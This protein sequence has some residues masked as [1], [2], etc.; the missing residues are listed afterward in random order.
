MFLQ[1]IH[2]GLSRGF[3]RAPVLRFRGITRAGKRAPNLAPWLQLP[4]LRLEI[5]DS[6]VPREKQR[7]LILAVAVL[8]SAFGDRPQFKRR[9]LRQF[10]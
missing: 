3:P 1:E 4:G 8:C 7:Q 9:N 2:L 5:E 10:R 6:H